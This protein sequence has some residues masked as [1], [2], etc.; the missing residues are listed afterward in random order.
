MAK[1]FLYVASDI[2]TAQFI[3]Y[4]VRIGDR[5]TSIIAETEDPYYRLEFEYPEVLLRERE[6]WHSYFI[7]MASRASER[8]TC[9]SGRKVGAV[10]V[11]N[12]VPLMSGFNGVPSGYPHPKVCPRIEAGCKSGEGLDMCPCNHAERN[13]INLA[14]KHGVNLN[15]SIL[16]CTARPCSGCIGD[17]SVVGVSK[18]IYDQ[19]YPHDITDAVAMHAKIEMVHISEV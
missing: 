4:D 13:A 8:T 15:G 3:Q 10:F 7:G 14:A 5:S 9:A 16:Y 17:L 6:D 18:V 11:A 12:K 1:T 19:H 2:L